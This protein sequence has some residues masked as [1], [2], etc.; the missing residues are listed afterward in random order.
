[1]SKKTT[2]KAAGTL[3]AGK[4]KKV[5]TLTEMQSFADEFVSL[6]FMLNGHAIEV[7][8]RRMR[9]D[10]DAQLAALLEGVMPPIKQ[11]KTP[12]DDRIDFQN[13]EF[14]KRKSAAEITARAL[15]I[16]WCVPIF[17][18]DKPNLVRHD[19]ITS[20]VQSKMTNQILNLLYAETRSGGI[21]IP[22]QVNFF[23]GGQSQE[24]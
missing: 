19:E 7:D 3:D 22:E 10:E 15:A 20:H 5:T 23:S 17:N 14:L 12:E 6:P 21:R 1:M 11:G 8:V 13:V 24:S 9:P 2:D 18:A 4:P 16:Y